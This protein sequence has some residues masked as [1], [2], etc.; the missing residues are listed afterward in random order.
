LQN[1]YSVS[2]YFYTLVLLNKYLT[3]FLTQTP[4]PLQIPYIMNFKILITV[5]LLAFSF[6]TN[7]QKEN[8]NWALDVGVAIVKYSDANSKIVGETS[9]VQ[10][11]RLAISRYMSHNLTIGGAFSAALGNQ[12]YITFDGFSRY[13]FGTSENSVVPYVLLGASFIAVKKVTPTINVGL[14][15]TFWFFEDY[16]IKLQVMQKIANSKFSSQ[17][18]HTMISASLVYNFNTNSGGIV[19]W[20]R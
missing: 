4:K 6:H 5:I 3:K 16:G 14:G 8:D 12:Q 19:G 18:S 15:S 20:N 7:A 2:I 11:P 13:D 1:Y 9:I 17:K 10:F